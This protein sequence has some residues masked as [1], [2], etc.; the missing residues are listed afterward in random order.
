MRRKRIF[1][2]LWRTG[3]VIGVA[4]GIAANMLTI[5]KALY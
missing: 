1:V 4:V 5:A 3:L 2:I